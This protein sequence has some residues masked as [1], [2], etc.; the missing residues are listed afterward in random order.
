MF[1]MLRLDPVRTI[2]VLYG[3][4]MFDYNINHKIQ[5]K[6]DRSRSKSKGL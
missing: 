5:E 4:Q 2:I 6:N 3:K 1:F